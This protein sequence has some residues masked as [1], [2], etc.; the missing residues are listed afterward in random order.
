M[1]AW[2]RFLGSRNIAFREGGKHEVLVRC[3]FCGENDPS[4]HL[5]ISLRGRGWRCLRTKAHSGKAYA[6]LMSNLIGCTEEYARE[7]L[8]E[9][10]KV[11]P[12]A[13]QFSQ[14]W[15]R[16]LGITS[17]ATSR[18]TQITLPQE[19]KPLQRANGRFAELFWQ[20][21]HSRGY[22]NTEAGWLAKTYRLQYAITGYYAYR[23]IVPVYGSNGELQT[24]TARSV[25]PD[26]DVRYLTLPS[27]Q[28]VESAPNLLLGLDFL[29]RAFRPRCL[30][31][32]EGPFDAMAITAL[33]NGDG[34]WGTCLFGVQVSN[35]QSQLLDDLSRKFD[36]IRLLVD[37]DARMKVLGFRDRLPRKC[38]I[39][40]L[41]NRLF[42]LKDPGELPLVMKGEAR[43][44]L[45][46]LVE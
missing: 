46:E 29:W 45:K 18:P 1:F 31:V 22:T 2:K 27:D 25:L 6:R 12:A 21:L 11:L 24:W 41:G 39:V 33:G 3:P 5:S 32:T 34:I 8:G 20:Y 10:A 26:A 35:A 43:D 14:D 13:D 7:L 37:P 30:V 42:P 19:F 17:D 4:Q 44:Y 36:R 16:Q 40:D 38:R 15:R 23:L 9:E 28:S